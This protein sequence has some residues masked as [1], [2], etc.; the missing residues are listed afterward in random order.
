MMAPDGAAG[1]DGGL[2]RADGGGGALTGTPCATDDDCSGVLVC[3]SAGGEVCDD[4]PCACMTG[5]ECIARGGTDCRWVSPLQRH[6]GAGVCSAACRDAILAKARE[7]RGPGYELASYCESD[8][9]P[10]GPIIATVS[11]ISG[12]TDYLNVEIR[13]GIPVAIDG[14]PCEEVLDGRAL[15]AT[16]ANACERYVLCGCCYYALV[17]DISATGWGIARRDPLLTS[18]SLDS[19]PLWANYDVGGPWEPPSVPDPPVDQCAGTD[20]LCCLCWEECRTCY[21]DIDCFRECYTRCI[22]CCESCD[23]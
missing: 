16:G 1:L 3:R 18:E 2:R 23:W 14:V 7:D 13:G 8:L 20:Q 12:G 9:L 6:C 17:G 4:G 21:H 5:N 15:S 10:D 11:P 22:W 19:C